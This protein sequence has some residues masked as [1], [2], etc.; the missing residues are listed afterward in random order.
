MGIIARHPV[1]LYD[2]RKP[3]VMARRGCATAVCVG[4]IPNGRLFAQYHRFAT[5]WREAG[6]IGIGTIRRTAG[7]FAGIDE[8]E[9]V[10]GGWSLVFYQLDRG[11]LKTELEQIGTDRAVLSRIR[12]NRAL[13]QRGC[14]PPGLLTFGFLDTDGPNTRWC[15][16]ETGEHTLLNFNL[17]G[18]FESVSQPGHHGFT[19][20]ISEDQLAVVAGTVAAREFEQCLTAVTKSPSFLTA[21]VGA[22]RALARELCDSTRR[23]P[24]RLTSPR[25][26]EG[27]EFE[28]PYRLVSVF[29]STEPEPGTYTS[30]QRAIKK[31]R[32]LME[33]R[34]GEPLT[35][36]ELCEHA[37]VSWRTLDYAFRNHFDLTPQTYLKALRLDAVHRLLRTHSCATVTHAAHQCGFRH[38]S[39]FAAH[40]RR[41]SGELP[42]ETLRASRP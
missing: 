37:G 24:G 40:Y 18:G 26:R 7:S 35:V 10:S 9:L 1:R 42:S 25:F 29:A 38:M 28:L 41:H 39:K 16:R 8:L 11:P 17:T 12:F 5:V 34:L 4:S 33:D 21:K 31:A 20:S 13:D 23:D 27:L 2:K 6:V 36:K 15:G 14:S 32:A 3:P 19:F 30:R 22:L